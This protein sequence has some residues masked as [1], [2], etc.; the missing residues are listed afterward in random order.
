MEF[1]KNEVQFENLSIEADVYVGNRAMP[2]IPNSFRNL[3]E[4]IILLY[5][6]QLQHSK[7]MVKGSAY[8]VWLEQLSSHGADARH[9]LECKQERHSFDG[10]HRSCER[11]LHCRSWCRW[12][13]HFRHEQPQ[14]VASLLL[15]VLG[16]LPQLMDF[17]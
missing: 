6:L 2:T 13:S 14:V 15:L 16:K 3:A 9:L 12:R 4:V 17:L 7:I 10:H 8:R 1:A 5:K 11:L